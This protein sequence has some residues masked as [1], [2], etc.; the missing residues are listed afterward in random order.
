[1]ARRT[2]ASAA[3]PLSLPAELTIYTVGELHPQWL[4]WLQQG[5]ANAP[6][7]LQATAVEQVDGAGL[8]LLL[9]LARA[10]T[11]RGR[12]LRIQSPSVVM[13]TGCAA[14]GL[15]SWLQGHVAEESP[16]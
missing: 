9:S 10:A 15:G 13:R 3:V 12:A 1:M 2:K 4:A 5:A 16:A 8:Q 7:E 14:L 11:E 6:A